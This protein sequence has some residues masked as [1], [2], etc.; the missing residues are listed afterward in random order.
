MCDLKMIVS[1]Y[2]ECFF[3]TNIELTTA[4]QFDNLYYV[5]IFF[6]RNS[7]KVSRGV[8]LVNHKV[9]KYII[10]FIRFPIST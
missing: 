2:S 5:T 6:G 1:R 8:A 3:N 9:C 7:R 10:F 4:C